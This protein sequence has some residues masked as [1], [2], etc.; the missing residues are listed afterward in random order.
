MAEA[1]FA[2]AGKPP[3]INYMDMPDALRDRYQY[4]TQAEIGKLRKVGYTKEFTS[5]EDGLKLYIEKYL[6]QA[7]RYR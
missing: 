5:L 2:A 1:M 3:K 7:D 6:S 4:F